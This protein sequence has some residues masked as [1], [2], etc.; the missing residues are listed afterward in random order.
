[1]FFSLNKEDKEYKITQAL[2]KRFKKHVYILKE[3]N[4]ACFLNSNFDKIYSDLYNKH[5]EDWIYYKKALPLCEN[6]ALLNYF[7]NNIC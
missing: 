1:M 5:I 3:N 6:Q 4:L 7:R 2:S